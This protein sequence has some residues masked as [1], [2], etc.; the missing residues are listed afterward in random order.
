[1]EFKDNSALNHPS[2][3]NPG[4]PPIKITTEPQNHQN[5]AKMVR[6]AWRLFITARQFKQ[7]NQNWCANHALP[8]GRECTAKRFFF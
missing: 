6:V 1:M 5:R 2:T 8:S 4:F 3:I 7:K